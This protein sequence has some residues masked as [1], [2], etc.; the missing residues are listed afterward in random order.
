MVKVSIGKRDVLRKR[1]LWRLTD[2]AVD[3][4]D[5]RC[6][7]EAAKASVMLRRFVSSRNLWK[8]EACLGAGIPLFFLVTAYSRR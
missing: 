1:S 6:L 2:S 4:L 5:R 8:G 7:V 3:Y